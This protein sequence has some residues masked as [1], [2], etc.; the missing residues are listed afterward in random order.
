[1][2]FTD[3]SEFKKNGF[4]G[5]KTIGE[6]IKDGTFI[7]EKPG[8][9]FILNMNS[10]PSEFLSIGS[11]GYFKGK[12]PNVSTDRLQENWV[13]QTPVV[14]IGKATSLKKRLKQYFS[15][16]QNKNVGHYGGRYIWQLKHA[17]DLVVCWKAT[18]SDP[19]EIEKELIQR[20]NSQ[21]GTLPFA[22]LVG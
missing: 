8:V 13:E 19:R 4:N 16:G 6:L 17:S 2:T 12:N 7:P 1:M 22:N 21:F 15:F 18:D 5:F 11:G 20:F 9:Y 3:I 14:Y 10:K